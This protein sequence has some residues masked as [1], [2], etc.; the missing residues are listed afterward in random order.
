MTLARRLQKQ[1]A[2]LA[3]VVLDAQKYKLEEREQK[4][5]I[6]TGCFEV[7]TACVAS[8]RTL[9]ENF[10]FFYDSSFQF[11]LNYPKVAVHQLSS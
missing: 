9:F 6:L 3:L 7:F 5:L 2:Y 4:M 10:K 11:F 1:F 8:R